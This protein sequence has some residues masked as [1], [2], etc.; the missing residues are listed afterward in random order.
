MKLI[1]SDGRTVDLLVCIVALDGL[2]VAD[3]AGLRRGG[4]DG[5]I[6]ARGAGHL[7]IQGGQEVLGVK[8]NKS[9]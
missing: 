9:L 4:V 2:H 6:I 1:D 3:E 7:G 8:A 5:V